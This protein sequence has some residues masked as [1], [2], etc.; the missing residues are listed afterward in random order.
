MVYDFRSDTV[1]KPTHGMRDAMYRAEVGDDVCR[2][3]PSI[4]RLEE[5]M[6]EKFGKEAGLFVT[7]GTQGNLLGLL[8]H[9][10]RGDEYIVGQTAHTYKYEGGGGAVLGSI[11]PQPLNFTAD[12]TIDLEMAKNAI[13]PDDDHF[14]NTRLFCLENTNGGRALPLDYLQQASK[15]AQD[16]GLASHLD[17]AR[18]FNAAVRCGVEVAEITRKFDTISACFSKGLGAPVGSIL[19]GEHEII[20]RARRWRKLLGGGTRQGGIIAAAAIYAVENNV[21]RLAE[22]HE[23]AKWL[24]DQLDGIDGIEVKFHNMQT[25]MVFVAVKDGKALELV[26]YLR[27]HG[28]LLYDTEPLRIV[29]HLDV[30]REAAEC[31]VTGFKNFFLTS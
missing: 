8:A 31:L 11:Q 13:K 12:G 23:N 20:R 6:A 5:L 2:E 18:V 22:D 7:S 26:A 4:N 15:F 1:T 19:C 16:N 9:C 30:G 29:C 17:G 28:V 10:E 27:K 21:E 14:A 3:D 25:N 24:A